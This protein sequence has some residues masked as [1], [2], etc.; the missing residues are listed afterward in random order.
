[1]DQPVT[2]RAVIAYQRANGGKLGVNLVN[3]G[4]YAAGFRNFRGI[5]PGT[6]QLVSSPGELGN[7]RIKNH[8]Q[9]AIINIFVRKVNYYFFCYCRVVLNLF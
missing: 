4:R 1:L 7:A 9:L 5:D 6:D 3:V 8:C 2:A